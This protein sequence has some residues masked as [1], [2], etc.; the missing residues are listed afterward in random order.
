[1]AGLATTRNMS[2]ALRK[3]VIELKE[4]MTTGVLSMLPTVLDTETQ[5]MIINLMSDLTQGGGKFND[6]LKMKIAQSIAALIKGQSQEAN[7]PSP[8]SSFLTM[9]LMMPNTQAM[10]DAQMMP[11]AQ[12][13]PGAL[14]GIASDGKTSQ[15]VICSHDGFSRESNV[16]NCNEQNGTAAHTH[17][18]CVSSPDD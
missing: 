13:L 5:N 2:L 3:A 14:E 17:R 12:M 1:M 9:P 6:L 8:S 15:E 4:N 16:S 11:S 18:L 10:P 7:P